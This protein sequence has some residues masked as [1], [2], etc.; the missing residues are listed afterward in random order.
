MLKSQSLRT[1]LRFLNINQFIKPTNDSSLKICKHNVLQWD[2][3]F[4]YTVSK[5]INNSNNDY[6]SRTPVYSKLYR[7][8]NTNSNEIK[9]NDINYNFNVETYGRLHIN[10]GDTADIFISSQ[11]V[12]LCPNMDRVDMQI[13]NG[14]YYLLVCIK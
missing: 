11:N 14:R 2:K 3:R 7:T 8:L 10:T 4:L 13:L 9:N 1:Y 5:Q 12:E 6:K